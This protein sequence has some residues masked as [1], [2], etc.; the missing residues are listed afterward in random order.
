MGGKM[1]SG[2]PTSGQ[3]ATGTADG[4]ALG[5][6]ANLAGIA[7]GLVS[8]IGCAQALSSGDGLWVLSGVGSAI[9]LLY[10]AWR[11]H[12]VAMAASV[13]VLTVVALGGLVA[14]F[15]VP[16]RAGAP[17]AV[18][19]SPVA[20][21]SGVVALTAP[22]GTPPVRTVEFL[23]ARHDAIDLDAG[24]QPTAVADQ[25]GAT[26][27]FDLY[28]DA[29]EVMSDV[30]RTPSGMYEYPVGSSPDSAYSICSDDTSPNPSSGGYVTSVAV[31]T[32]TSFCFRTSGGKLAFATIEGVQPDNSTAVLQVRIWN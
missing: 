23:L 6:A 5:K 31:E 20:Q 32:G 26:G 13:L 15:R 14:R 16:A 9:F 27:R 3:R 22:A 21:S 18:A 1:P 24:A 10:A 11:R 30:I 8:V 2:E 17:A 28:H 25:I 4:D 7:S 19:S 12:R 29:G